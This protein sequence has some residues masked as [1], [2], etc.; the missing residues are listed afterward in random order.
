M[1]LFVA[2]AKCGDDE[3]DGDAR[4]VLADV[5]PLS[6]VDDA[7]LGTDAKYVMIGIDLG[8]E[9]DG[10]VEG[11]LAELFCVVDFDAVAAEEV[12]LLIAR[13]SLRRRD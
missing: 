8:V 7:L 10:E 1:M 5:G 12:A 9:L 3:L 11:A 2:V 6:F 13:A 4:A